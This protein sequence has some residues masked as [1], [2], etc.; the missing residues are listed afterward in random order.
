MNWLKDKNNRLTV[1]LTAVILIIAAGF[2]IYLCATNPTK[3]YGNIDKNTENICAF[4][5][6]KHEG[7]RGSTVAPGS[8]PSSVIYRCVLNKDGLYIFR[9][10]SLGPV[11][12]D[13]V[14]VWLIPVDD[15]SKDLIKKMVVKEK[16]EKLWGYCNQLLPRVEFRKIDEMQIFPDTLSQGFKD[17]CAQR[18]STSSDPVKAYISYYGV[19]SFDYWKD[20][21]DELMES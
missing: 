17:Y 19:D 5:V 20:F 10:T 1:I 12:N 16:W 11:P 6:N 7:Y 2:I 13:P 15:D 9:I 21:Y 8:G 4:T 3:F 18:M 14:N